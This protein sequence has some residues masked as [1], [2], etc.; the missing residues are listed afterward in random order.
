MPLADTTDYSSSAVFSLLNFITVSDK[1]LINTHTEYFCNHIQFI[2]IG[3]FFANYD[4]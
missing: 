4:V 2:G 3:T 1:K